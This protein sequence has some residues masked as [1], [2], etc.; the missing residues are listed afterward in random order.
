MPQAF[1]NQ[2]IHLFYVHAKIVNFFEK[3]RLL[4]EIYWADR[5]EIAKQERDFSDMIAYF[6]ENRNYCLWLVP[7]RGNNR[8]QPWKQ[9][10]PRR[11]R[12]MDMG[13]G[14]RA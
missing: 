11:K 9:S 1:I 6:C 13:F 8:F 3:R 2:Q 14:F 7:C 10:F 12:S 5:Q 4:T